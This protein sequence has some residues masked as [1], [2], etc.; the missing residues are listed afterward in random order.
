MNH[1]FP[2]K[3]LIQRLH[4]SAL[5]RNHQDIISMNMYLL[6][7]QENIHLVTERVPNDISSTRIRRSVQRGESI[8]FL[9][10]DPVIE[11]IS[12]NNLYCKVNTESESEE[13]K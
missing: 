2:K 12:A 4:N 1:Y 6:S 7:M 5:V 13:I 11:Y 10:P 9:L 3:S 8:K